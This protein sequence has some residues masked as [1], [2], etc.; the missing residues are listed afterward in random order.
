MDPSKISHGAGNCGRGVWE[1]PLI[2]LSRSGP[3]STTPEA[4]VPLV[5][6]WIRICDSHHPTCWL[7]SEASLPSRLIE[8]VRFDEGL[9]RLV[10]GNVCRKQYTTLSYRWGMTDKNSYLTSLSNVHARQTSF[11]LKTLPATIRDAIT[12][13]HWLGIAYVWIDAMQ[14]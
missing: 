10:D 4:A 8:V 1:P 12:L 14:V 13:S 7:E 9:L 5:K 6:D 11:D 2:K 3:F